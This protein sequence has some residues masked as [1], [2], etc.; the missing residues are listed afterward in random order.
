MCQILAAQVPSALRAGFS[1][2]A[3]LCIMKYILDYLYGE[4]SEDYVI[5]GMNE[6]RDA[7]QKDMGAHENNCPCACNAF[8]TAL[9]VVQGRI[10]F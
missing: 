3:K 5:S 8:E 10:G 6:R 7:Y 2:E 9:D 1:F 4:N